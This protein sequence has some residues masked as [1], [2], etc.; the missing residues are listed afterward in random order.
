MEV[1]NA[2]AYTLGKLTY[3]V[4]LVAVAPEITIV[5]ASVAAK[6]VFA[7]VRT[8]LLATGGPAA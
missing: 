7:L 2:S 8:Q 4:I 6:D 5:S 1:V 3:S